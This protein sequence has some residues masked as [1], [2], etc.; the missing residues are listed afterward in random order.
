MNRSPVQRDGLAMRVAAPVT[1]FLMVAVHIGSSAA[2]D[3]VFLSSFPVTTLPWLV[4]I[5]ALASFPAGR[6]TGVALTRFGPSRVV[7]TA[8]ALSGALFVAEA[9]LLRARPEAV[10]IVLYLHATV[11]GAIAIS[12]YWSLLNER[13]DPNTA[14]RHFSRVAG[15]ASL[16]AVSGGLV[17]ERVAA[18]SSDLMLLALLGAGSAACVA[19][20]LVV[21]RGGDAPAETHKCDREP[22]ARPDPT[23]R[24]FLALLAAVTILA[25][26]V[27]TL[28][29]YA[30]KADVTSR[31]AGSAALI[32]FFGLF[33]AATGIAA[34]LIQIAL[35][36][37][38]LN[39]FHGPGAIAVHPLG[40]LAAGLLSFAVPTPWRG[41][42]LRSADAT[43]RHSLFRT[44]YELLYTPLPE[45]AKRSTKATID[46]GCDCL[47]N[48]M[49]AALL[50]LL[51]SLGPE[52]A[53]T[54]VTVAGLAAAG[55]E[56]VT[57]WHLR[58]GYP[59]TVE[60]RLRGAGLLRVTHYTFDSVTLT[61]IS[62]A[63]ERHPVPPDGGLSPHHDDLVSGSI[64]ALRS[65]DPGRIR[66]ALQHARR[67]PRLLPAV[68]PLLARSDLI[69]EVATTLR[70]HGAAAARSLVDALLDSRTPEAVRRRLP[71]VLKECDSTLAFEGLIR[72]LDDV[73]VKVR[74][75]CCRALL[76]MV[77]ANDALHVTKDAVCA[78]AEREIDSGA[79]DKAS[80]VHVFDLLAL[81]F[82]R[83]ILAIARSA[84]ETGDAHLRGIALEY[85]HTVL[86]LALFTKVER[87]MVESLG[88]RL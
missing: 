1:A 12:A 18:I 36:S 4:G 41:V 47:G 55:V 9:A 71:L 2:R 86:P 33:Y 76:E 11:L 26:L 54:A 37:V 7:P 59:A 31:M 42:L 19:G 3:A 65:D 70:T 17:A 77:A 72:G 88:G 68:V 53:F 28:C 50:L 52:R 57:A 46:V 64:A 34:F 79:R 80:A 69:D 8:F 44:G 23:T 35:G 13:F 60:A 10:S 73:S 20:T 83:D 14:R 84:C 24:P 45:A 61:H 62:D 49:G 38:V 16:G 43:L 58:S 39:R 56:L 63:D 85:L 29:D 66:G 78:A 82:D 15:A 30:L 81:A 6:G 67:E 21:A 5:A 32:Q 74:Q 25:A 51:I 40:V 48:G 22:G 87:L 27:G 75:R